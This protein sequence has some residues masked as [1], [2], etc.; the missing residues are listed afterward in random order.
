MEREPLPDNT[1]YP[2][3]I[4]GP[5][6]HG[7][8]RY[9]C[10]MATGSG[11]TTVMAMLSAWSILNKISDPTDKRF[12]DAILIV[13][14]NVTIRDRLQ[15]LQPGSPNSIYEKSDLVP[16]HFLALLPQGRVKI[17]NWHVLE[18]Q[19]MNTAGG[20]S[21][22]VV[23]RGVRKEVVRER[24]I[25]GKKM[26]V[27]EVIYVESDEAVIKRVLGKELGEKKN[28]LVLN[29]EAHHAYRLFSS[30]D[31]DEE[32]DDD[33]KE[34]EKEI[35]EATVWVEG[36]DKVQRKRGINFCVDLSATPYYLNRTGNDAGKI[37]PWVV[38]DF[39][40]IDAIESGLV[41]IPQLPFRDTTGDET[42]AYFNIWRWILEKQLKI[43][44]RGTNKRE[45]RPD[46]ILKHAAAPIS[47]LAGK[48][49][50]ESFLQW[51]K[52]KKATPPVFIIVCKNTKLANIVYEWLALGKTPEGLAIVPCIDEFRNTE[53][54]RNTIRIDSKVAEEIESGH[55]S[56]DENAMMRF[57][58]M[59]VGKTKWYNDTVPQDYVDLVEKMNRKNT[60]EGKPLID[61]NEPPGKNIRCIVSV[62]MLTEG[63]DCNTVTHIVG[64]RPFQSQLLCEQVVG[65]GLR[66]ADYTSRDDKDLLTEEVAT[67][68][69]V[70]FEIIPFKA[71]PGGAPPPPK[72]KHVMALPERQ[73]F[74]IKFPRVSGYYYRVNQKVSIDWDKVPVVTLDPMEIPVEQLDKGL[75]L[76]E[77]G[78]PTLYGVGKERLS[79]LEDW[80]KTKR[81]QQLVFT[82]SG[83]LTHDFIERH[84]AEFPVHVLFPQIRN[85]VDHFVREKIKVKEGNEKVDVFLSPYYDRAYQNLIDLMG[86][87]ASTNPEL[88]YLDDLFP[89]SS[90]A[91]VDYWTSKNVWD[92]TRS[93]I[94]YVVADTKK[95]EQSTAFYLEA[96]PN[97][98]CYAKNTPALGFTIPYRFDGSYHDYLPDFL[99]RIKHGDEI[100][101]TLILET[102]GQMTDKDESKKGAAIR[103]VKA[104]N[105]DGR[106]GR[107]EYEM[108]GEPS[109]TKG[110]VDRAIER[111]SINDVNHN[112]S[113][114]E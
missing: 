106:F 68:Y 109:L 38:S 54:V 13:C 74:E 75:S 23:K 10:K 47:Q 12:S 24:K 85:I 82:L 34:L 72:D 86:P 6:Y 55:A 57:I 94:N 76:T 95:W 100:I 39:G 59:T 111:L 108:V 89:E 15:E 48:W 30:N 3:G 101:G 11:K 22:R 2:E 66:R 60:E 18:P 98:F 69:G 92:A 27:R 25:D 43:S 53:T 7:F 113:N 14:P 45:I 1:R 44:E 62:S 103:W 36:L 84:H 21:S 110:A 79:S 77:D 17:T 32:D 41:K 93:H 40:L 65:R 26:R 51:Q 99:V 19:E 8:T 112:S 104:V 67:V 63:W 71:T 97:V 50:E 96:H 64:L 81:V 87:N 35:K 102:K 90:T 107:W 83:K 4:H 29:D 114:N 56:K 33:K 80:R 42:P 20:D 78:R 91:I 5:Q 31:E 52:Q 28:I 58:L 105:A 46:A 16:H 9:G 88:P 61:V 70:P 49:R 37:F 73:L